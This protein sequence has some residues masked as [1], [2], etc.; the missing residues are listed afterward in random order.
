MQKGNIFP[1][2]PY[3]LEKCL[4]TLYTFV[5]MGRSVG[6]CV[7]EVDVKQMSTVFTFDFFTQFSL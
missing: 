2:S 5:Q 3:A 7:T 4:M 6:A 1:R